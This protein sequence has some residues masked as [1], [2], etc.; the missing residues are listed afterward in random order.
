MERTKAHK[1]FVVKERPREYPQTEQQ[2]RFRRIL[3]ECGII[4]GITRDQLI[5]K[6][7]H[8]IPETWEKLKEG[9]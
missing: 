3:E 5:D 4:K 9:K 7:I 8:C 1:I 2:K 6:M